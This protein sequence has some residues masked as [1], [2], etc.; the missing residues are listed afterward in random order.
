MD[1]LWLVLTVHY[2]LLFCHG[3]YPREAGFIFQGRVKNTFYAIILQAHI[4]FNLH[5]NEY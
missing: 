5:Q 4:S 3:N 1:S 2:T